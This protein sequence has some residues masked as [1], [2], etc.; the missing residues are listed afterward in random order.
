[1]TKR[2]TFTTNWSLRTLL[3]HLLFR[4]GFNLCL[5]GVEEFLRNWVDL[6]HNSVLAVEQ[7]GDLLQTRSLGLP[8]GN[9]G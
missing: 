7:E 3:L 4:S 1:M 5:L 6:P 9:S 8:R 2:I